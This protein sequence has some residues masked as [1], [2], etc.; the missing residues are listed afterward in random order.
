M[1]IADIAPR[2][3]DPYLLWA[4]LTDFK[5]YGG[6]VQPESLVPFIVELRDRGDVPRLAAQTVPDVQGQP[7]PLVTMAA[8]YANDM[9]TRFCTVRVRLDC[10][11]TLLKLEFVVRAEMGLAGVELQPPQQ[12]AVVSPV[13]IGDALGWH[14]AT[15]LVAVI[16]HGIAFLNRQF[17]IDG[18]P[19]ILRLWDQWSGSAQQPAPVAPPW[20]AEIAHGYGRTISAREIAALI[21]SD[22]DELACYR[23]VLRYE[24]VAGRAAHGTHVLDVAAG[25]PDPLGAGSTMPLPIVAVQLPWLPEKDVSGA[26]LCVHVLDAMRFILDSAGPDRNVVVNLSDGAM[27]GSHNA[28]SIVEDAIDELLIDH[29]GMSLVIAAGNGYMAHAHAQGVIGDGAKAQLLWKVLPDDRTESFLEIWFPQGGN[30]MVTL[31]TPGDDATIT[32]AVDT[33]ACWP[34]NGSPQAAIIH[35]R[36]VA[37]GDG[38]LALLALRPS[39]PPRPGDGGAPHGVWTVSLSNAAD[40]P[41]AFEAWVERDDP[42]FAEHG[43]RRQSH[44]V[45]NG[46]GWISGQ[47]T[48]NSVATGESPIVVGGYR[49]VDDGVAAYS[50]AGAPRDL[51]KK[52][53]LVAP[54]DDGIALPGLRAAGNRSGSSSRMDGTSVAAPIVTRLI[55][56][57]LAATGPAGRVYSAAEIK[58]A[59]RAQ[60]TPA[61]PPPD[62][63]HAS[64]KADQALRVGSGWIRLGSALQLPP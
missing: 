54:S 56:N 27:A 32:A 28:G 21:A 55:A 19:R 12:D 30:V 10:I 1:D 60:A 36:E 7:T 43:P 33:S 38:Q 11:A 39:R 42:P 2:K 5:G 15:P 26:S 63:E 35:R 45:D 57:A 47:N 37:N 64:V 44:F 53:T 24:P 18:Q 59:L 48:L 16:D 50:A 41:V 49:L 22:G 6:A 14:D 25:W 17:H 52:P 29:P 4:L 62:P 34:V 46:E 23:N 9:Q 3:L 8:C 40:R 13:K 61:D 51:G 31:M 58:Q 20:T